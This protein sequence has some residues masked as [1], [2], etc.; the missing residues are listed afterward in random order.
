MSNLCFSLLQIDLL[1]RHRSCI[2]ILAGKDTRCLGRCRICKRE[3]RDLLTIWINEQRSLQPDEI[4]RR[5]LVIGA[6]N[7]NLMAPVEGYFF[8]CRFG[9]FSL[10]RFHIFLVLP[11]K[12]FFFQSQCFISIKW[13]FLTPDLW[14]HRYNSLKNLECL[15]SWRDFLELYLFFVIPSIPPP[16][17]EPKAEN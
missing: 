17:E 10:N 1:Q 13:G 4:S 11:K 15:F 7:R 3:L 9:Y 16:R 5:L 14:Y 12:A 8:T 2:V 6:R